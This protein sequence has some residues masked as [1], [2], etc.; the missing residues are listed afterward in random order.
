ME[1][2]QPNTPSRYVQKNHLENQILGNKEAYVQNRRKLIESSSSANFSL[3]SM[4][5]TQN[6]MQTIQDDHWV[7][8]MNE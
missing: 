8:S 3:L 1:T 7:K 4:I 5:E 2:S 6:F